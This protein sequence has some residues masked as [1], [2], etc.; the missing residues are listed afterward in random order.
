M[1]GTTRS[2][3]S[4]G[5]GENRT[6]PNDSMRVLRSNSPR[7]GSPTCTCTPPGNFWP[8]SRRLSMRRQYQRKCIRGRRFF[9]KRDRWLSESDRQFGLRDTESD[10]MVFGSCRSTPGDGLVGR[11]VAR[12]TRRRPRS[13]GQPLTRQAPKWCAGRRSTPSA[14]T[15]HAALQN[16]SLAHGQ[17]GGRSAALGLPVAD[18]GGESMVSPVTL[19]P[20][21]WGQQGDDLGIL[22]LPMERAEPGPA[23]D[24]TK[25]TA[26]RSR[27][28]VIPTSH[29]ESLPRERGKDSAWLDRLCRL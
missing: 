24:G 29:R 11:G 27:W 9:L 5:M 12:A 3:A 22:L 18:H 6:S 25:K 17:Q 26:T 28:L 8:P 10:D 20:R 4:P 1:M 16:S 14:P 19:T 13:P 2:S 15:P 21:A 23:S 7:C